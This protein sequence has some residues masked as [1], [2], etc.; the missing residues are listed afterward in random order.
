MKHKCKLFY[1]CYYYNS[2]RHAHFLKKWVITGRKKCA[3]M[4]RTVGAGITVRGCPRGWGST[5]APGSGYPFPSLLFHSQ[6]LGEQRG[7]FQSSF[8]GEAQPSLCFPGLSPS[9]GEG[10]SILWENISNFPPCFQMFIV[11]LSSL[12][13]GFLK[14]TSRFGKPAVI[15][16]N[17][18]VLSPMQVKQPEK[19]DEHSKLIAC[20]RSPIP[21]VYIIHLNAVSSL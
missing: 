15:Q 9:A 5:P 10:T 21:C 11:F 20:T 8:H 2:I 18:R 4:Y 3:F 16:K 12:C 1:C 14:D 7:W 17:L 13:K 6:G 19:R